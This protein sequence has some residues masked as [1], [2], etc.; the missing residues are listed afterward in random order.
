MGITIHFKLI[1]YLLLQAYQEEHLCMLRYDLRKID[2]HYTKLTVPKP[3]QCSPYLVVN[4]IHGLAESSFVL[5]AK[6]GFVCVPF[7]R[8]LFHRL[9]VVIILKRTKER[10]I[11]SQFS[12]EQI[13][14]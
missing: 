2:Q 11:R 13:T 14:L 10:W 6:V 3:V 7:A 12:I 1:N 8:A 5:L 4:G 9:L